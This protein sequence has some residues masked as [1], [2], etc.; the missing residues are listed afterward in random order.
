MSAKRPDSPCIAVCST[1]VGDDICRGCARSFDE[2]SQWC[3]MDEEERELVW[4]QLPLRQRGLKIAAVFACLPQLHPRDDGE[5]MSVPCLP[6]LFRMDGDCLW[7]RRGEEAARQRDCAG[8]GPAQVA[9][10][11][12]E[13]AETDSN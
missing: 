1:A 5:W 13:Q 6:W 9:A 8:W 11:L 4:Q 7:W 2:I 3:F 10:F 12:R